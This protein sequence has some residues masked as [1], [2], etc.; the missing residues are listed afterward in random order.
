MEKMWS[1][2]MH[3]WTMILEVV[4]SNNVNVFTAL[5]VVISNHVFKVIL[6]I[7]RPRSNLSSARTSSKPFNVLEVAMFT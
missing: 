3:L 4:I 1:L 2:I 7:D 5:E 6:L